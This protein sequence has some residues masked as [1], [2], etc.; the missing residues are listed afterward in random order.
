MDKFEIIYVMNRHYERRKTNFLKNLK[1]A[2]LHVL[3]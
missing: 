2:G 1:Y 3:T